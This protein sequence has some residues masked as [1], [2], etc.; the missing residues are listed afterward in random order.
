M[1]AR[2][3]AFPSVRE[4]VEPRGPFL[5]PL[6]LL[7]ITRIVVAT[8]IPMGTEDAYITYRYAQHLAMGGGLT[9]NP[10]ERVMGFSS[11]LWTIWNALGYLLLH[12]PLVWS[13]LTAFVADVVTLLTAGTLLVR[14]ASTTSAWCFAVFF[15][16]WPYFP[17]VSMS[18]LETSLMMALVPL[19]AAL[20]AAGSPAGG[21]S[22]AAL[23][24]TRPE[25][26]V[27]A[28]VKL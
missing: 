28:L 25:G 18:G 21:V 14:Y 22:L 12:Q 11:P 19:S 7:A 20:V 10:G 26:V 6:V 9:Y 17:A 13:R 5:V 3:R 23:A 16:A 4:L 24:L 8:Q 15:A 1:A 2:P 27:A